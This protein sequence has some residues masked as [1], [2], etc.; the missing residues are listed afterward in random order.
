MNGTIHN[1]QTKSYFYTMAKVI[2]DFPVAEVCGKVGKNA[3]V[4]FAHRNG[5][6]FMVKYGTRS[7]MPTE[8]EVAIRDKF[9]AAVSA[10]RTRMQDPTQMA[11][12]Q[13]A[14]K[15]QSRYSTLY[16]YVFNQVYQAQD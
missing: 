2:F 8:Q 11:K 1:S 15:A 12:D 4:G 3:K 5:K 13:A 14:F 6:T 16:G 7:T 10:T 9:K